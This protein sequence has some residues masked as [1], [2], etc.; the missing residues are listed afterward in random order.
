MRERFATIDYHTAGEP[1]RIVP[2]L[3]IAIDGDDVAS[4]RVFAAA[5]P[6][7][8][9][10]RRLL[11]F[12]P[13]GHA[14]MYGGFIVEPDDAGAHLGVLFWHK[15]GFSTACGHGTIALGV[16]AIESG[17]VTADESGTTDVVID[18]PSG[19]VTARVRTDQA[20]TV[21][22]AD[23]INVPGYVLARRVPVQ[24]SRGEVLADI[25][26]AGAI[27]AQVD[28]TA[29]GLSIEPE[30]VSEVIA[31][32]REVKWLLNDSAHAEHPSD[33]RLNGIYGTILYSDHSADGVVHQRNAT[34]FA[35]GELD[36]SPCGS[37]TCARVATLTEE[38]ILPVGGELVHDSIVGSRFLARVVA[39]GVEAGHRATTTQV[40]G[41]AHKTGEHVFE[42]DPRDE[43]TPGFV[44]R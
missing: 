21:T 28:A 24:T 20:G 26:F 19:R 6:E 12:E 31:F 41:I 39:E 25:T 9:R 7:V 10:A 29:V 34:V 11:C 14:D 3:G 1:F 15:D 32:G 42:V 40:S 23:F 44:L 22:G 4:K 13:R 27:Y 30:D 35:D 16:W 18:V 33:R 17:L 43:M 8:D 38:G 36:R 2:D 37:G 5:S